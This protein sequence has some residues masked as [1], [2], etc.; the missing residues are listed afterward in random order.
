M[1]ALDI[2]KLLLTYRSMIESE[3]AST[4][5]SSAYSFIILEV[6]AGDGDLLYE[7]R[8]VVDD[9]GAKV[10]KVYSPDEALAETFRSKLSQ[11][12]FPGFGERN[13]QDIPWSDEVKRS[14]EEADRIAALCLNS[15]WG[16]DYHPGNF[17]KITLFDDRIELEQVNKMNAKSLDHKN[18]YSLRSLEFTIPL[19]KSL[20]FS[21]AQYKIGDM[22][23]EF[24]DHSS[25][26]NLQYGMRVSEELERIA[27]Q[28]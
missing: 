15:T 3:P 9:A 10:E 11:M 6:R 5:I 13:L 27:E 28:L 26:N 20:T 24:T 8:F 19:S 23:V 25:E 7:I 18:N 14:V 16:D 12:K 22:L 1:H 2:L 17:S 4:V 21:L